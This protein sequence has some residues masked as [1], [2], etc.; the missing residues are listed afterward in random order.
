M[1]GWMTKTTA[2]TMSVIWHG[3]ELSFFLLL[4]FRRNDEKLSVT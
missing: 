3:M 2:D 4:N 1:Y